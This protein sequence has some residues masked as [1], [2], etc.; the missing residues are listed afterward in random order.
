MDYTDILINI[1]K[2]LRSINLESKQVQKNHGISLPQY[3]CLNFLNNQ[4]DF[5]ATASEIK[6]H[7]NLNASTVS[8]II[9]RLESKGCV[10]KLP[11]KGD[12]RSTHIYLTALGEKTVAAVPDLL[13][14][15]LS[16]KLKVLSGKDLN[17]IKNA[18]EL[19]V[20]FMEVEDMDASPLIIPDEQINT[21]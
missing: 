19:L 12:K 1:R 6:I 11:N 14:E 4:N 13:H 5:N 3:L 9:S 16:S 18:L 17:Q 15:K 21:Q 7:L 2:I 8:G 20:K 10:A